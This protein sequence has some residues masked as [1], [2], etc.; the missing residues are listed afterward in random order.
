MD[1]ETFIKLVSDHMK[2]VRTEQNMSQEK[3]ADILGISKKTLVQ[4]E[5]DR[6]TANWTIVLAFC[7]LFNH[8]HILTSA[9]GDNP[10]DFVQLI[11]SESN[12][13]PKGKTMGGNVWWKEIDNKGS[14]RLQQNLISNHYRILDDQDYRW[15]SSFDKGECLNRLSELVE[16][17]TE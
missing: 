3:M 12:G 5:K 8:S 16:E 1:R 10:I 7:V 14:F 2:L 4:I 9:I 6:M 15:Y 13:S 11:A 17:I